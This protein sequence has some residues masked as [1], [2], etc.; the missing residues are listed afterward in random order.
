MHR[1]EASHAPL[2]H[3]L[4]TWL[5]CWPHHLEQAASSLLVWLLV[6]PFGTN[7]SCVVYFPCMRLRLCLAA[8]TTQHGG[9]RSHHS[10]VRVSKPFVS[11]TH[12]PPPSLHYYSMARRLPKLALLAA[13]LAATTCC[14]AFVFPQQKQTPGQ[15]SRQHPS[16]AAPTT[17][18]PRARA[19]IMQSSPFSIMKSEPAS[20]EYSLL[21]QSQVLSAATGR[22][23]TLADAFPSGGG[24]KKTIVAF[25]THWGDF[26]R[27]VKGVGNERKGGMT[28]K[29]TGTFSQGQKYRK[30]SH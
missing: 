17:T 10:L 25:F 8:T 15:L 21:K 20:P 26:N 13:A 24:G 19:T 16:S 7:K 27:C 23:T 14:H 5:M 11:R 4:H 29:C 30:V 6:L 18:S 2:P 3:S 12:P 1:R 22:P 9:G 28:S